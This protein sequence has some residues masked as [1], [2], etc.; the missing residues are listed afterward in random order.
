MMSP[1]K[2]E[3]AEMSVM[4]PTKKETNIISEGVWRSPK[5]IPT[6]SV[7]GLSHIFNEKV[8]ALYMESC[9]QFTLKRKIS[10]ILADGGPS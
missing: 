7:A 10:R 5:R 3:T 2:K 1:T 6:Q 9:S 8:V 4:S